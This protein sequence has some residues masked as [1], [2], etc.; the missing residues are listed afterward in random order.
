MSAS[1]SLTG[2]SE[3]QAKLDRIAKDMR[4]RAIQAV[5]YVGDI[6][7]NKSQKKVPVITG[8]LKSTGRRE[9]AIVK[10]DEISVTLFYGGPDAPYAVIVHETSRRGAKYLEGP[11]REVSS[12][13]GNMIVKKMKLS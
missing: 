9:A 1:F 5:E 8:N 4:S 6:V 12:G 2:V 10:R 13:A 7:Y 3:L 11:L